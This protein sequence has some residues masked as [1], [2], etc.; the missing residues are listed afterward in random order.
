MKQEI[1]LIWQEVLADISTE[2]AL[3]QF[4]IIIAASTLAWAIN[5][6]LRAYVMRNAPENWKL[7]I[8]GINRVLFPLSTLIFVYIAQLILAYWQHTS[9]LQLASKLLLAMAVIR[10][11]VYAVRYIVAPGGLLKTLENTVSGFI[12]IVTA[13]HLSGLLPQIL[14]VLEDVKFSIGKNPFNLLLA[15]QAILTI[16]V[17][18]FIT[19][20]FSRVVEN[21]LMSA[22]NVNMNLRVVLAKLLRVF[23]LFIAILFALSAVGLDITM[24]SVFGGAL[25]V[26]LGFGLQRIASNY[27]SGFIILLDKSMQIG[28]VV[29]IDTHYGVVSDLRTRYLVL[30]KLDGT[31]V[32]IPNETLIINPVINHSST[33]HKA[34]VQMPVQVSYASSLEVAMELMRDIAFR[35]PR[36]LELPLPAVQIQG[37][38]ES[39]IDLVLNLWIPDPEEGSAGLKTEIYLE[40]WRAFQKNNISIPYPQREVRIL[41]GQVKQ[42]EV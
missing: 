33:D 19:L 17:T 36:V 28:D 8:G 42:P 6:A 23:L 41:G 10:L 11:V 14:N 26:G 38:G 15:L 39:G 29:T 20:W 9:L 35:H 40:I 18:I 31:E 27:V 37:F 13:L 7:G 22:Q 4:A 16:L 3:W 34:R 2:A 12:W 1:H 30:R 32:I 5:G 25:G 21:R 24:L